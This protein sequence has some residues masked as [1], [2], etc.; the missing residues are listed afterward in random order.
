MGRT[1]M[2]VHRRSF[3][4]DPAGKLVKIYENVKPKLHAKEVLADI[5]TL[6]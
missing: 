2:G 5:E 4:I 3:L 1:Y 6:Q